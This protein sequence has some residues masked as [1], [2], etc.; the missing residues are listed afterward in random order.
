MVERP[1][2]KGRTVVCIASGPSLT[3]ED[4]EKV[5]ASGHP[6]IVT[7]TTFQMCPWADALFAF[8]L[9]WWKVYQAEVAATFAGRKF[10]A[11]QFSAKYGAES[12]WGVDWFSTYRNSGA[13]AA[14][15]A[16]AG[17]AAKVILLGYDCGCSRN[18]KRHWHDDHPK[19]LDNAMMM[20]DWPRLFGI[21]ARRAR[22]S[23]VRILN[24]SRSTTLTC[25]K[26]VPLEAVL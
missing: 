5:R 9:K 2:W 19:G 16:M 14:S 23:E 1:D 7:N 15:L 3:R 26:R 13:C 18:N 21:L 12:L 6:A 11:S 8:D 10:S 4:A 20:L 22:H 24:A 17:G 25:F